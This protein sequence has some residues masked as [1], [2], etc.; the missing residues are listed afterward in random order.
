[1]KYR[2]GSIIYITNVND[3]YSNRYFIIV[4]Y[5]KEPHITA[6]CDGYVY[7]N[8]KHCTGTWIWHIMDESTTKVI[9]Y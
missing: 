5:C 9:C 7:I 6:G 3:E 1:M 4:N 2:I 8:A